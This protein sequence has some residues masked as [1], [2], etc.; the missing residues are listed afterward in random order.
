VGNG[1]C[2]PVV[3]GVIVALLSFQVLFGLAAA[4]VVT[5]LAVLARL[6]RGSPAAPE[7]A[8]PARV[9]RGTVP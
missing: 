9:A 4:A 1:W 3:G 7:R 8:T 6:H 2:L 5:R